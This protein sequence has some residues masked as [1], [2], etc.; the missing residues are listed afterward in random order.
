[1][2]SGCD[3]VTIQVEEAVERLRNTITSATSWPAPG[4]SDRNASVS[5]HKGSAAEKAA[6]PRCVQR[7][8]VPV[9]LVGVALVLIVDIHPVLLLGGAL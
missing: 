2:S 3:H 6:E 5:K 1:M 8:L 7:E 4:L 9:V